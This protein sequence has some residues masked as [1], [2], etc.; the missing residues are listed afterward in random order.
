MS[1]KTFLTVF[2]ALG[3]RGTSQKKIHMIT[4]LKVICSENLIL[5]KMRNYFLISVHTNYFICIIEDFKLR[6]ATL[7]IKTTSS[8]YESDCF[9]GAAITWTPFLKMLS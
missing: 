7:C 1:Q 5:C 9:R 8:S 3:S 4:E 6:S 2:I